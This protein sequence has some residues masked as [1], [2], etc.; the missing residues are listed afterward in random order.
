MNNLIMWEQNRLEH[1]SKKYNISMLAATANVCKV[2][3]VLYFPVCAENQSDNNS[4]CV[5]VCVCVTLTRTRALKSTVPPPAVD[6]LSSR[7]PPLRHQHDVT[8]V[9]R[10]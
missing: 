8:S 3:L 5:C 2:W 4:M 9:Y 6:T 10:R 7:T 1:T